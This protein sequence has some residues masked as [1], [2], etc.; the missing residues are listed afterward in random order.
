MALVVAV[1]AAICIYGQKAAPAETP[2]ASGEVTITMLDVGQGLCLL[3]ESGEHRLLYD[4]GGRERSSY[5]VAAMKERGYDSFDYMIASHYDEDHIAG[6]IGC[7][8]NYRFYTLICPEYVCDTAIYRSFLKAVETREIKQIH[9]KA[10]DTFELGDARLTILGPKQYVDYNDN[11]NSLI[12]RITCGSFS[13]LITG[14]AQMELEDELLDSGCDLK[15]DL[16]IVG[17]HGSGYSS[18]Y[19]F[20]QKVKPAAAFIS[21]GADN[22]YG[23]PDKET[24]ERLSEVH[25]AVYR[26]DRQGELVCRYDGETYEIEAMGQENRK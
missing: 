5:V 1:V 7:L 22:S 15:S 18:T 3:V 10:G 11:N 12:V 13:C 19:D 14:D 4:G 16:Y 20:I 8:Y 23:H 24:L 25:A 21:C 17:H 6:L 2:A 9:P 26:T